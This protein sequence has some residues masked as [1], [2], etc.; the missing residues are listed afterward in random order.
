M[1]CKG[2]KHFIIGVFFPVN[3]LPETGYLCR[4]KTVTVLIKLFYI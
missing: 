1:F 3:D 2:R 4:P